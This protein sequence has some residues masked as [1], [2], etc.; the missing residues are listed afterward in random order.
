MLLAQKYGS[1]VLKTVAEQDEA[2]LECPKTSAWWPREMKGEEEDSSG[3]Q[4][5]EIQPCGPGIPGN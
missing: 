5:L 2:S 3:L 4:L 1:N